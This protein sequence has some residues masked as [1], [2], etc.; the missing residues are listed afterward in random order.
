MQF[1][2]L[3]SA[4]WVMGLDE[5]SKKK[6]IVY[7]EIRWYIC[8]K[9]VSEDLYVKHMWFHAQY[10]K[11]WL[12]WLPWKLCSI[13]QTPITLWQVQALKI[14]NFIRGKE[15]DELSLTNFG[16]IAPL[17]TEDP[18]SPLSPLSS[19]DISSF[20][21]V[22]SGY[23]LCLLYRVRLGLSRYFIESW[24]CRDESYICPWDIRSRFCV[25]L[26]GYGDQLQYSVLLFV[27]VF[28]Y[29]IVFCYIYYIIYKL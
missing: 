23:L 17:S 21:S 15:I 28:C 11:P 26:S 19:R 14:K 9:W 8:Y 29:Y 22:K 10:W 2:E 6:L 4:I 25:G 16:G 27:I 5:S 18:L 7:G 13:T 24:L 12:P 1:W 20:S 3:L